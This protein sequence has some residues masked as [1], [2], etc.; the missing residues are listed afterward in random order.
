[1]RQLGVD[2]GERAGDG[3]R[4]LCDRSAELRHG[5]LALGLVAAA[6]HG[7]QQ[8]ELGQRLGRRQLAQRAGR[9]LAQQLRAQE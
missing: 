8:R 5:G 3:G 9:R 7:P 1:M 2:V 6:Q 4:G